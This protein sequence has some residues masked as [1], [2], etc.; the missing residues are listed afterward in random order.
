M[1]APLN[2]VWDFSYT[3]CLFIWEQRFKVKKTRR[4]QRADVL[5]GEAHGEGGEVKKG[6]EVGRREHE[7]RDSGESESE[8]ARGVKEWR[9]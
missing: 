9:K 4:V 5:R 8:D 6:R 2:V 3:Y 1:V 7:E